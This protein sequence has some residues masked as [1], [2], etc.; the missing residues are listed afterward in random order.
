MQR[1]DLLLYMT[2]FSYPVRLQLLVQ[3]LLRPLPIGHTQKLIVAAEV[4]QF[5]RVHLSRQPFPAIHAHLDLERKPRLQTHVHPTKLGMNVVVVLF[6]TQT[7]PC[8]TR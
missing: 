6:S 2:E 8:C 5:F 4:G 3:Q 7:S 1:M